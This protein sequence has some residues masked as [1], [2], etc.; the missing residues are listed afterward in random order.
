MNAI[1]VQERERRL[2]RLRWVL[3]PIGF[4]L[5]LPILIVMLLM[6]P[7]AMLVGWRHERRATRKLRDEGRLVSLDEAVRQYSLGDREFVAELGKG[8]GPIW[9]VEVP[10]NARNLFDLLPTY[11][12]LKADARSTMLSSRTVDED[13]LAQLVPFLQN[14]ARVEVS[15]KDFFEL[16]EQ[17]RT[18]M[19]IV[20]MWGGV[21]PTSLLDESL[22]A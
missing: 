7:F 6:I 17:V 13:K 21:S 9:L 19:R 4:V 16:P 15:A 14:A 22:A 8:I 2:R 5:G 12:T 18:S 3:L 20:S 11:E 10:P 1:P